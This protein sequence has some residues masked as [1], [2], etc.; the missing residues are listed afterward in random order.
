MDLSRRRL[1]TLGLALIGLAAAL[2]LVAL[3][4]MRSLAA[5]GHICGGASPHC[6]ACPASL[7]ALA[8][9]A[10]VLAYAARA[11]RRRRVRIE[12]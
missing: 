8:A 5:F 10:A 3:E 2:G 4:H 9:G 12:R 1:K 11:T 6:L 7:A